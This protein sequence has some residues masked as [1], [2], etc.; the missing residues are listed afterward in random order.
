MHTALAVDDTWSLARATRSVARAMTSSRQQAPAIAALVDMADRMRPELRT[1]ATNLLSLYGMLY[2]AASITAAER[3]QGQL[4]RDMHLEAVSAA[5]QMTPECKT[6]ATLFGMTN[7]LIHR[8][9]ALVR[10]HEA[11]RAL[12]FAAS[13]DRHRSRACRRSG[14]RTTYL[15]S[16]RPTPAPATTGPHRTT[17]AR[18]SESRPRRFAVDRSHIACCARCST[19]PTANRPDWSEPWPTAPECTHE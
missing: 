11:G 12:E 3:D 4:A 8:V 17:S 15:I 9:A 7:V 13:I 16:P 5:E 18:Q 10:L 19:T 1:D 6:H 2:L 14:G